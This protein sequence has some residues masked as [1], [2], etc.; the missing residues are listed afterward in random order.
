MKARQKNVGSMAH[1]THQ[2]LQ[3]NQATWNE[4][5]LFRL[6]MEDLALH[7]DKI[8]EQIKKQKT[9]P[10]IDA[11][12]AA[13]DTAVEQTLKIAGVLCAYGHRHAHHDLEVETDLSRSG[14]VQGR[15]VDIMARM[16]NIADLAQKHVGQVPNHDLKT[17]QV[18]AL[19]TAA[20]NYAKAA[21]QPRVRR[22]EASSAT[23][24]IESLVAEVA[25]LYE[26]Q[27]DKLMESYRTSHPDFYNAYQAARI[28]VAI[29]GGHASPAEKPA[30]VAPVPSAPAQ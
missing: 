29:P 1:A 2:V 19:R 25:D 3:N 9:V 15:P 16:N 11:K 30:A 8:N 21:A 10:G 12:L 6:A 22:S 5:E 4:S 26:R 27:I 13:R 18:Q 7:F 17:E 23:K 28:V 20:G 14:L 24:A